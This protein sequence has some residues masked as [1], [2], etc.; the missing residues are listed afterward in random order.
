[1]IT[2]F[3]SALTLAATLAAFPNAGQ[4]SSDSLDLDDIAKVD[5]LPGWRTKSG[6]H[7]AA[8]RIRLASGWKTYWRAPGDAG[9][10]PRFDWAGSDNLAAVEFHWPTPTVFRDN[11][12]RVIGYKNEVI[13]PLELTPANAGKEMI[14]L[15][16]QMELG[17]C[18]EICVPIQVDLKANLSNTGSKNADIQASLTNRP[19]VASGAGVK[20][21][22]CQVDPISDGLRLT[23]HIAIPKTG[24]DEVAVVE[25]ADQNVWMSQ[26]VTKREGQYL[27]ATTEMVPPSAAPFML[28]RSDIRITIL[29]ENLAV[30]ISGC[31]AS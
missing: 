14:A 13:I 2:H 25:F 30:D 9:I 10:P 20:S 22:T 11:G 4:A 24:G 8:V 23:A 3:L 16:G 31:P 17:V 19:V 18:E 5:I 1:M 29:G 26:A 21:V 12:T 27:I 28:N 15:R 7:M 6:R